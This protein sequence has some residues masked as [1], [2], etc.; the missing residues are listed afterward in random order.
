VKLARCIFFLYVEYLFLC[1]V[2]E[3]YFV[4]IC[5]INFEELLILTFAAA[6]L[7]FDLVD[8]NGVTIW[9]CFWQTLG[10]SVTFYS[11]SG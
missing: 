4:C 2:Y 11:F 6:L 1:V 8:F 3:V 9:K 10:I 7:V 5:V